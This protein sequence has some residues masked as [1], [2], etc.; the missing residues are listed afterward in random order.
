ML[1]LVNEI[2]II[3]KDQQNYLQE[4]ESNIS[5]K[6]Y[7]IQDTEMNLGIGTKTFLTAP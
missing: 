1:T 3:E 6:R 5:Q 2:L 4:Y 7:E